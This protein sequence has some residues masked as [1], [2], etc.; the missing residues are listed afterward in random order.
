MDKIKL[1]SASIAAGATAQLI[2]SITT[3]EGHTYT[4]REIGFNMPVGVGIK[5]YLED[6][7]MVDTAYQATGDTQRRVITWEAVGGR[8]VRVYG[9]NTTGGALTGGTELHYEDVTA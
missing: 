5:I 9:S 2:G 8:E 3:P 1:L 4:Y 6:E 7:L